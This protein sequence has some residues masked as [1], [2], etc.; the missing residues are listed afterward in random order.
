M[1]NL[2]IPSP[3]TDFNFGSG[4]STPFTSAPSSPPH[5]RQAANNF[6]FFSAPTSPTAAKLYAEFTHNPSLKDANFASSSVPFD[7]EESPGIPKNRVRPKDDDGRNDFEFDFS[8]QLE[9]AS[10]SADELFDGGKIKPLK[11]PPRLQVVVNG[12]NESETESSDSLRF[13]TA[14]SSPRISSNIFNSPRRKQVVVDPFTKA[15]DEARKSRASE[16]NPQKVRQ[17]RGRDQNFSLHKKTRSL[18]PFRVADII[19]EQT[20]TATTSF[21]DSFSLPKAYR[22]W[23]IRD[24]LFRSASEGR[25]TEKLAVDSR[26]FIEN[27]NSSFRSTETTSVGSSS[28]RR[29]N[30]VP[31][32]AHE[33][34]YKLNRAVSQEM[35]KKTFLPY[36]QGLLGCLGFVPGGSEISRSSTG[37]MTRV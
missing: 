17:S 7:W 19:A 12:G 29:G 21:W 15:L 9:R 11:P 26:R 6:F 35:R 30:R 33:L 18:S 1:E 36:K 32:S 37:S 10:L 2:I 27:S 28:R 25:A 5:S 34:H 23:K 13:R 3:P 14:H 31:V 20:P 24:L 16:F 22:K 8:G 4:C